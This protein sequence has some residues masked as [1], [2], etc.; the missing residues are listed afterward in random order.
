MASF[1]NRSITFTILL[2]V[3]FGSTECFI[4]SRPNAAKYKHNWLTAHA[5]DVGTLIL[6]SSHTFYGIDAKELDRSEHDRAFN[7]AMVAQTYRYDRYLLTHYDFRRLHTLIIPFSYFSLYEDFESMP[8]ERYL[9]IRYRIYMDCDIHSRFSE[10]GMEV[11]RAKGTKQRIELFLK[12]QECNWDAHGT[13]TSFT[14]KSRNTPWDDGV[15]TAANN[16]Y[17]PDTS[18]VSLNKR[19]LSEIFDICHERNIDVFLI[20]TP[21]STTF[22]QHQDKEQDS[23]NS[24]VL[25][26]LLKE[27]PKVHYHDFSS[28]KRFADRD[29]HDSHHLSDYGQRK[30]TNILQQ[31]IKKAGKASPKADQ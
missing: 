11:F 1:I 8:D 10:Y 21:V 20:T 30:F 2:I 6:G 22:K 24:N 7:L 3:V 25:R 13:G 5:E 14:Y 18:L 17:Y 27:H 23:I 29:Y 26:E 12:K 9:A 15:V 16:T 28:D 31:L 19:Y 4:E